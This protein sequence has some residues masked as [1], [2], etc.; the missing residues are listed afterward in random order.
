MC[1]YLSLSLPISAPS[2]EHKEKKRQEDD[3]TEFAKRGINLRVLLS[4]SSYNEISLTVS[5]RA[6]FKLRAKVVVSVCVCV[7]VWVRVAY[8]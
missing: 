3:C 2:T 7:F 8:I 6:K 4:L 5:R 1:L